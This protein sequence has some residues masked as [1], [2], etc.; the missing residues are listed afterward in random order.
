MSEDNKSNKIVKPKPK[1]PFK[2]RLKS[3]LAGIRKYFRFRKSKLIEYLKSDN[4]QIP[5]NSILKIILNGLLFTIGLSY[6]VGFSWYLIPI[7]G[8]GWYI[9]KKEILPEIKQI[10]NSI[11]LIRIQK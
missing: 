3:F 11:N 4:F 6:F 7:T 10:F 8:C 9:L 1:L 2:V 5:K